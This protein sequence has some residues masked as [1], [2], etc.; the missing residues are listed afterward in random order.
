MS[1]L[2][3]YKWVQEHD[4]EYRWDINGASKKEDVI[5]WI[6]IYSLESFFKLLPYTVFDDGGIEARLQDKCVAIWASDICD[7]CGIDMEKIFE[8]SNT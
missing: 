7:H 2:E 8:K 5:M 6:S 3:L 4:P 1:E